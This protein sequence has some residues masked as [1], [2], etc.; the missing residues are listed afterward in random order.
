MGINAPT[1]KTP[2]I[3]I[4]PVVINN[5]KPIKPLTPAP[6][7]N[8][9]VQEKKEEVKEVK[10]VK[11]EV[12]TVTPKTEEKAVDKK[13]NSK[14]KKKEANI[15]EIVKR[16]TANSKAAKEGEVV[17]QAPTKVM[18]GDFEIDLS[19]Y[20]D[21]EEEYKKRVREY[22]DNVLIANVE[23]D[24]MKGLNQLWDDGK[25][26]GDRKL[27]E[28]VLSYNI[29]DDTLNKIFVDDIIHIVVNNYYDDVT[30]A[31]P[32]YLGSYYNVYHRG[33]R[34]FDKINKNTFQHLKANNLVPQTFTCTI[35]ANTRLRFFNKSIDKIT[36]EDFKHEL[37]LRLKENNRLD[38]SKMKTLHLEIEPLET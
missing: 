25:W 24:E 16:E 8:T 37:A 29:Y 33:R 2:T 23:T 26:V 4:K 28:Y 19:K 20:K 27:G 3:G 32:K 14:P 10:E 31:N 34:T 36:E 9:I 13:T 30:L 18:N 5:V 35:D 15:S 17:K 11:E 22:K 12:K 38:R 6:V 21:A 7:V 1:L